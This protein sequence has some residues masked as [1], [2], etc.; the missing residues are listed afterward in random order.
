MLNPSVILVIL[1]AGVFALVSRIVS[2][3]FSA[4][5]R[6]FLAEKGQDGY[7]LAAYDK[8]PVFGRHS[9]ALW[10]RLRQ[11]WWLWLVL[12]M[13]LG[14]GISLWA[15]TSDRGAFFVATVMS[16]IESVSQ[17]ANEL[18]AE[19]RQFRIDLKKF[20]LSSLD[21][22]DQSFNSLSNNVSDISNLG[23]REDITNAEKVKIEA[24]SNLF[25]SA[26]G[27]YGNGCGTSKS[28]PALRNS[29]DI[30][31]EDLDVNVVMS[32]IITYLNDYNNEQLS[33][34]YYLTLAGEGA[35][36]NKPFS[37]WLDADLRARLALHDLKAS[38]AAKE[39]T[40]I[41]EGYFASLNDRFDTYR[42]SPA[43]P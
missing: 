15:M 22:V 26:I 20:I 9:L 6:R 34:L 25:R 11:R 5:F 33:L 2:D 41:N 42:N 29:A 31:I 28:W 12:G 18:S 27:S 40:R 3:T 19:E 38:Q 4:N 36:M 39:L 7:L 10:L 24:R 43:H 21:G 23:S 17:E 35:N 37:A 16:K 14:L 8:V 1:A 32:N 30:K 13:A